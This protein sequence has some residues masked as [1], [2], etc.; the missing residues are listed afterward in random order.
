MKPDKMLGLHSLLFF[1][2]Q[3]LC[4]I[5]QHSANLFQG[6]IDKVGLPSVLESL[7]VHIGRVQQAML[8]MLTATLSEGAHL[9]RLIQDKV[10]LNSLIHLFLWRIVWETL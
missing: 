3:A 6:V 9:N 10:R 2:I 7:G 5:T 4:R 8:T 1:S